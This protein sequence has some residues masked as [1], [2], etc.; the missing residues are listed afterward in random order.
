M[1]QKAV[2]E[3]EDIPLKQDFGLRTR[4]GLP[5][6]VDPNVAYEMME[7]LRNNA[8]NPL[9][10]EALSMLRIGS[11]IDPALEKSI[12]KDSREIIN[13]YG[14]NH[15]HTVK[16][17]VFVMRIPEELK[18]AYSGLKEGTIEFNKGGTIDKEMGQL[19][20]N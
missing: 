14:A 8:Y 12:I 5:N 9:Y 11:P 10:E 16:S 1:A 7:H 13:L 3:L 4:M 19:F 18:R 17:E 20:A 2:L 6:N 15:P